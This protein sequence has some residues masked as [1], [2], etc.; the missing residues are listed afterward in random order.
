MAQNAARASKTDETIS[1]RH[2]KIHLTDRAE[3]GRVH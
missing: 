3:G 1:A 2:P